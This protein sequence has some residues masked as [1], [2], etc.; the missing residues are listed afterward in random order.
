MV[1]ILDYAI[2]SAYAYNKS[3][4]DG[5]LS[6][7]D[8]DKND[9]PPGGYSTFHWRV[10]TNSGFAA[11]YSTSDITKETVIAF[12]GT[13]PAGGH[14]AGFFD[15]IRDTLADLGA[16]VKIFLR[17]LPMNQVSRALALYDV[18]K[19]QIGGKITLTGHSLGGGLAQVVAAFNG[20]E[21]V[22]FN[23]PGMGSAVER[24]AEKSGKEI[25]GNS[26]VNFR[27]S[28]DPVSAGTGKHIGVTHGLP[29][30]NKMIA[31]AKVA[32]GAKAGFVGGAVAAGKVALDSHSMPNFVTYLRKVSWSGKSA[33]EFNP[34]WV[35]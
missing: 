13:Q 18:V 3:S 32:L 16:D 20:V 33:F 26:V 9:P 19:S 8:I 5:P 7:K 23:A 6:Q 31:V 17:R 27:E 25:K 22:T 1:S 15:K 35:K 10:D 28:L 24:F 21:A 29:I 12:R 4:E 2:L 14:Q 11:T 30:V 34:A